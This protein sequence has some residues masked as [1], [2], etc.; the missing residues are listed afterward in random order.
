MKYRKTLKFIRWL[1]NHPLNQTNKMGAFSRLLR[2]QASQRILGLDV[3]LPFVDESYLI[4]RKGMVGATG[5]WYC[6]LHEPN[7]M[8]FTLHILR[9]GNLFIDIG[10]NIGSYSI[11]AAQTGA[12]VLAFEPIPT[13]FRDLERNILVNN[14]A[15]KVLAKQI[16]IGDHPGE[17]NFTADLS[18]M[19]HVVIDADTEHTQETTRVSISSLDT[20]C[21]SEHRPFFIKIDVEGFEAKVLA[22][23][24]ATLSLPNLIG[25]II[26]T[27]GNTE[28]FGS[29]V[30]NLISMI[31]KYNLTPISYDPLTRTISHATP[32][33]NAN[34]IF[35]RDINEAKRLTRQA[36]T[37][38]VVNAHI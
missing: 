32:A 5:N 21:A 23:A 7:E 15:G 33:L 14:L 9:P 28:K 18:A 24:R 25:L 31:E 20:Y 1:L 35:V 16:G 30:K 10:A 8:A 4:A 12:D 3:L 26:E 22:G 19:N 38:R 37:F 11:L 29:S 27:N 2:W 13:T 6:G 36:R 17:L 34:T